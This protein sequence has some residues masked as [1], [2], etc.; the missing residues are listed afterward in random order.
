MKRRSFFRC[1]GFVAA[2]PFLMKG[3]NAKGSVPGVVTSGGAS[4]GRK[5][6]IPDGAYFIDGN[7]KVKVK[8][9][10][11]WQETKVWW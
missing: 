2:F 8:V 11:K 9:A 1:L 5:L 7:G 10:G 4:Q 6:Q 3:T